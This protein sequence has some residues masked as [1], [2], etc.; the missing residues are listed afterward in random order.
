MNT[1]YNTLITNYNLKL[2]TNTLFNED[3]VVESIPQTNFA[4]ILLKFCSNFA[5]ILLQFCSNFAGT[6]SFLLEHDYKQIKRI[7]RINK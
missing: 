5:P 7:K 4:P 6:A 2:N 3:F 1:L